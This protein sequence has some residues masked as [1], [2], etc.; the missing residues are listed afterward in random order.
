[1]PMF[2]YAYIAL[3]P[4]FRKMECIEDIISSTLDNDIK[5]SGCIQLIP[6]CE[7][8]CRKEHVYDMKLQLKNVYD[9]IDP[10]KIIIIQMPQ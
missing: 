4:P 10:R 2:S 8:C 3:K 9:I 5:C 1:M 7:L 6:L